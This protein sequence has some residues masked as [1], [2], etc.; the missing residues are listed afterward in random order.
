MH[1][2]KRLAHPDLGLARGIT[3]LPDATLKT[4]DDAVAAIE[5]FIRDIHLEIH[6]GVEQAFDII[7]GDH[8][9]KRLLRRLENR[10]SRKWPNAVSTITHEAG[11]NA[12]FTCAFCGRTSHIP[13]YPD[14]V[15]TPRRMVRWHYDDCYGV[16]GDEVLT[17][18]VIDGTGAAEPSH[19]TVD[20]SRPTHTTDEEKG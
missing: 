4:I 2:H 18:E 16:V 19:F 11:N 15:P 7:G 6:P 8:D 17:V 10:A 3:R 1:R 5:A 14:G 20:L 12:A 13:F 9:V